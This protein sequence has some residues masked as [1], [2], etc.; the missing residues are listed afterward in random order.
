VFFDNRIAA[1]GLAGGALIGLI[2]SAYAVNR[3]LR[4]A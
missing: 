4:R 2:G 1:F 3:H